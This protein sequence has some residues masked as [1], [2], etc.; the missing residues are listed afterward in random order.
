MRY[1]YK[2]IV[3]T[4]GFMG[5]HKEELKRSD[6]DKQLA[7]LGAEGWELCW[8]LP[9][10]QLQHEKDGHVIILKRVTGEVAGPV[11]SRPVADCQVCGHELNEGARFCGVC[12]NPTGA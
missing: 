5:R 3:L 6:L 8:V 1:E 7:T 11:A 4:G 9:E 2:T 12:G 10:M